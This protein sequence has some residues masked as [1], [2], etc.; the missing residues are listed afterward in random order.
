MRKAIVILSCL[1]FAFVAVGCSGNADI[2]PAQQK[3]YED[4]NPKDF[5]GPPPG[6]GHGG[7]PP[8]GKGPGG[9]PPAGAAPGAAG[10]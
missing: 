5:H 3:A 1:G 4:R 10:K 9:A 2:P 7:S 6:F 8:P